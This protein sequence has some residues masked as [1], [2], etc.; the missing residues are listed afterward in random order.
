MTKKRIARHKT[1][2]ARS[3]LS[4]PVRLA[5]ECGLIG[6]SSTLLDYGCGRGDDLRHL[7]ALGIDSFGWDPAHYPEGVLAK[8]DVVNLGYAPKSCRMLGGTQR[9]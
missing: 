1:A 4:R 3:E 6:A 7:G 2:R 9:S 8:A 5:H